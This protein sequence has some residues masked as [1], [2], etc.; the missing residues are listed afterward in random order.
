MNADPT[1]TPASPPKA[2]KKKV[3]KKAPKPEVVEDYHIALAIEKRTKFYYCVEYHI[4][5]DKVVEEIQGE[6]L[7]RYEA[8]NTFKIRSARMFMNMHPIKAEKLK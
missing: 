7:I 5:G 4:V 2:S 6:A 8:F 3:S 1:D